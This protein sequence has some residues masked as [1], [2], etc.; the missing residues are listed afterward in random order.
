MW[1][2][3]GLLHLLPQYIFPT[4]FEIAHA[5]VRDHSLLLIHA[6]ITL[7]EAA[8]GLSCGTLLAILLALIMDSI[9]WL[10]RA[11][12]PLLILTQTIPTVALAPILVLWL[13]YGLAP[14][15]VLII[16]TTTF[17]IVISILDGFRNCDSDMITLLQLMKANR[18]AILWHLK[19]PASMSYFYA[20]FRVSVSYA[21]LSA[22][23]AE[24]LGGFEGLGVYMIR[25]KKLFQYDTMFAII[26]LVSALSLLCME[27]V[28]KSEPLLLPWKAAEQKIERKHNYEQR[29]SF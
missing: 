14:K 12:Y 1:Q 29:D 26:T 9:S 23:V 16:L 21:I 19:I 20:G 4:P 6:R 13:G 28:R 25:A 17:P 22:V 5:F 15:V 3:A 27:G 10:R 11:I 2:V 8:I 24:W 18:F 7:L